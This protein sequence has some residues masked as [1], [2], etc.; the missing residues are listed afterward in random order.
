MSLDISEKLRSD[1]YFSTKE[2]VSIV[3]MLSMPAILAQISEIVMQYIDAAMVGTLGAGA[4]A[5]IGLVA[6]STWLFGGLLS[7][8]AAGFAV[9]VSHAVGAGDNKRAKSV[10]K[11][12][13]LATI[14]FSMILLLLAAFLS[15]RLPMWLGA[16]E[17]LW[18]DATNYFFVFALFIPIRMMSTLSMN[19]LQC[20]GNMKIP[21]IFL[22]LMCILDV[23]FNYFLI[24]PTRTITILG[25]EMKVFGAGLGVLGAQLGT[26]LSVLVHNL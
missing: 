10:F 25:S 9:Q 11:Q 7:A 23:I 6:S 22:T 24:F 26:S 18:V 14:G 3:Y 1:Y 2:K 21:S 20:S 17:S 5:S 19:M 15:F 13:I 12:S 8:T 16:E 4:S